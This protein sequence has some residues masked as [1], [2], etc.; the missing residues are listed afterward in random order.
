MVF[1]EEAATGSQGLR[2]LIFI[3]GMW[4]PMMSEGTPGGVLGCFMRT[5]THATEFIPAW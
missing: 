1:P 4:K 2:K 3:R 5:L